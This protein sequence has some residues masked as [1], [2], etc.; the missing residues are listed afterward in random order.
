MYRGQ[1]RIHVVMLIDGCSRNSESLV[2]P[3]REAIQTV[4]MFLSSADC[5]V[6]LSLAQPAAYSDST[7]VSTTGVQLL[8]GVGLDRLWNPPRLLSSGYKG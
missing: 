3:R 1:F 5:L 2:K 8:A 7:T 4:D 6:L